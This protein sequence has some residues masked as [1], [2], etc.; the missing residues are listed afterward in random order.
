MTRKLEEVFNLPPID[1]NDDDIEEIAIVD[2]PQE[3]IEDEIP[4]I[5]DMQRALKEADKID[6]ALAP[7][8]DIES[9]DKDMDDYADKAMD[10]FS[11]LMDLGQNVEDRH[12]ADVFNAAAKMMKNAID[13]KS[14][15]LDR[16]LK[17]VQLQMQKEKIDLENRKLD[18]KIN[19]TNKSP[20]DTALTGEGEVIMDRNELL[21]EILESQKSPKQ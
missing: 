4:S 20:A 17:M 16:K 12:C 19:S 5:E 11:D 15:K 7:V 8:K 1:D 18:H 2:E 13:A 9:L 14:T 10:S 3:E 6:K 21:K